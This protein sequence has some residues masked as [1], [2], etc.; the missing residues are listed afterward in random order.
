MPTFFGMKRKKIDAKKKYESL[1]ER[2]VF[3]PVDK[4]G[5]THPRLANILVILYVVL[6]LLISIVGVVYVLLPLTVYVTE[7]YGGSNN[8]TSLIST[9]TGVLGQNKEVEGPLERRIYDEKNLGRCSGAAFNIID[10]LSEVGGERFVHPIP[11]DN[12]VVQVDINDLFQGSLKTLW[13]CN[14]PFS[15]RVKTIPISGQSLGL[16]IEIENLFKLILGDGDKISLK[17][18]RNDSGYRGAWKEISKEKLFSKIEDKKP[19]IL[20][21]STSFSGE[22]ISV[23]VEVYHSGKELPETFNWEFVPPTLDLLGRAYPIRVGLND[24]R[25]KGE[26]SVVRLETLTIT[27]SKND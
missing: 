18:E 24:Y 22:W 12:N 15:V 17:L 21:M 26:G 1:K 8:N 13:G 27:E 3:G 20:V 14:L 4:I 11:E 25:F 7:K 5:K 6:A 9:P 19:L 23:T 16:F 2:I 10:E